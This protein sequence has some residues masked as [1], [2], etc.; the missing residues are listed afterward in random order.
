MKVA[1][2]TRFGRDLRA[3]HSAEVLAAVRLVIFEFEKALNLQAIRN[4]K[5]MRGFEHYY[6]VRVGEYRIGVSVEND[7]VVFLRCLNRKEIY[8]HFP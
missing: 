6:R 7:T 3:V 4:L 5:K 8:R 1:F 2:G